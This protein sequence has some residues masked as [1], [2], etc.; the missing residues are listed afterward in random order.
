MKAIDERV[1][2]GIERVEQTVEPF[3]EENPQVAATLYFLLLFGGVIA[4]VLFL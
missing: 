2:D 1:D 3:E 4:L